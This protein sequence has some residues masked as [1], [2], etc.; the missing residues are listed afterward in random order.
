VQNP[1]DSFLPALRSNGFLDSPDRPKRVNLHEKGRKGVNKKTYL[2]SCSLC[3]SSWYGKAE[4]EKEIKEKLSK[5]TSCPKGNH[6]A[7]PTLLSL[8]SWKEIT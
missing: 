5:L 3:G 6:P 7:Y 4:N 8:V 2:L 1:Q